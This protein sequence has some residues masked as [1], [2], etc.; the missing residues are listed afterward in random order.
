[1]RVKHSRKAS[2]QI[3]LADLGL[4]LL[5]LVIC[6]V[7]GGA[8][9]LDATTTHDGFGARGYR[10][11]SA[12]KID[13]LDKKTRQLDPCKALADIHLLSSSKSGD[14]LARSY[15]ILEQ[16]SGCQRESYQH[17]LLW[18]HPV[19][20][21]N[22]RRLLIRPGPQTFWASRI[23]A[24]RRLRWA[25]GALT[26]GSEGA[27]DPQVLVS[28]LRTRA[29]LGDRGRIGGVLRSFTAAH[30][31]RLRELACGL[32]HLPV[33]ESLLMLQ[34]LSQHE[35]FPVRR[36]AQI[37]M[38]ALSQA[39]ENASPYC[40]GGSQVPMQLEDGVPAVSL[41]FSFAVREGCP[42]L[43]VDPTSALEAMRHLDGS[44][45]IQV[46]GLPTGHAMPWEP[47]LWTWRAT[48]STMNLVFARGGQ[49]TTS[50]AVE[51][52][53]DGVVAR[54]RPCE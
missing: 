22:L 54:M 19:T 11:S 7:Q 37:S 51:L 18:S 23:V 5:A 17:T 4:Y 6:P 44:S 33:N 36:N 45:L 38:V 47:L 1:M 50:V 16:S 10:Q 40:R 48:G 21:V 34:E 27:G 13:G 25:L 52:T 2:A 9:A 29:I 24:H 14:E 28:L 30:P 3:S 20:R 15:K 26:T 39:L 41:P 49:A 46:E 43:A 31:E 12:T 35:D 42:Y 32:L 8:G 53:R